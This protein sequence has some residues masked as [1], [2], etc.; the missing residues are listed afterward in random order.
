MDDLLH[1]V[2]SGTISEDDYTETVKKLAKFVKQENPKTFI[3]RI[4]FDSLLKPFKESEISLPK[5]MRNI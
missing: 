1:R 4:D 5:K 2:V 3:L